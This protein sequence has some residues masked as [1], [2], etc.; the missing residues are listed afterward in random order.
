MKVTV[1]SD[2]EAND[3]VVYTSSNIWAMPKD[4]WMGLAEHVQ[5]SPITISVCGTTGG[6]STSTIKIAPAQATGTM[7]FWAANPTYAD[8]DEHACQTSLTAACQSA[9]ELRGFSVG[10]ETTESVLGIGQVAQMS[11]LDSGNPAP[12]TCIGCHSATPTR[13]S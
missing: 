4:I 9:A 13:V 3:L 5:D 11:R 7:V 2:K 6:Q 10:D 8:I 1:H 12:V